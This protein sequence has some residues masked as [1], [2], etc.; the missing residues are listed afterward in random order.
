MEALAVIAEKLLFATWQLA[1]LHTYFD[2][3]LMHWSGRSRS[4]FGSVN[5]S[6]DPASRTAPGPALIAEIDE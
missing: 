1:R 6:L 4:L 3:A 2:D 5:W